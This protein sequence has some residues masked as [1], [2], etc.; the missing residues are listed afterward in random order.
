M[1]SV[2]IEAKLQGREAHPLQSQG[3]SAM[4]SPDHPTWHPNGVPEFTAPPRTHRNH[5]GDGKG[6]VKPPPGS[7][8]ATVRSHQARP[9]SG[10]HLQ[11]RRR[12]ERL[13]SLL[14]PQART[15]LPQHQGYCCHIRQLT[16][17]QIPHFP[18][19][20]SAESLQQKPAEQK[21]R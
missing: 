2:N 1:C 19:P 20:P 12:E 16:A 21:A 13:F 14:S 9:N 17:G 18:I 6:T 8:P 15:M 3:C 4:S 11:H 10:R 7:S 5:H